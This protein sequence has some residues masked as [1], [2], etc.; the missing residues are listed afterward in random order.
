MVLSLTA[1]KLFTAFIVV[2]WTLYL[3]RYF[4]RAI[5]ERG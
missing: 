2:W 3:I 5:A 1:L 4:R